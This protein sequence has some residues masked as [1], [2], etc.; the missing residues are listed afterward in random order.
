MKRKL[1][2]PALWLDASDCSPFFKNI[3]RR[4]VF[5]VLLLLGMA[6]VVLAHPSH[7]KMHKDAAL[8]PTLTLETTGPDSA[9][10]GELITVHIRTIS[11]FTD[12]GSLQY[13]V[14]WDETQLQYVSYV[15]TQIGGMGGDPLLGTGNTANGEL[16]YSWVDPAGLDGEDLADSTVLL[17]ITFQV[18]T[19]SG[20]A[21]V[22]ITGTPLSMEVADNLLAIGTLI[23]QNNADT[24]LVPIE[25]TCPPDITVYES[26]SP[27]PLTGGMPVSG[28]YSG[29][30]VSNDSLFPAIAGIGVHIIT[31]SYTDMN[32]CSNTCT[33]NVTVDPPPA[34]ICPDDISVCIGETPFALT[35]GLPPGGTY[36]GPGVSGGIF[37]PVAAGPGD[38]TI[39]YSVTPTDTCTFL[40][41]VY[42]TAAPPAINYTFP[43]SFNVNVTPGNC[44]ATVTIER[45]NIGLLCLI[46]IFDNYTVFD[47]DISNLAPVEGPAN[48]NGVDD[49]NFLNAVQPLDVC[50][51]TTKFVA[52]QFPVGTTIIPYTWCDNDSNCTTV[53]IT[54]IVNEPEPPQALCQPATISLDAN[55]QA[56]LDPS[57]VDA[58]STD[59]CGPVT[60][61]VS[62]D[63]F[64][65]ADLGSKI[66]V[67]TV[68]DFSPLSPPATCTTTVTILDD[69]PP[70]VNCPV[71]IV[72]SADST[73]CNNT[74]GS[75][76]GLGLTAIPSG[77]PLGGP[78]EYTDNCG[79]KTITYILSGPSGTTGSGDYPI[80][81]G[82]VFNGG[83]TTVTYTFRDT[84]GNTSVCSFNVTVED[85]IPPT[86]GLTC[87]NPPPVNANQGGCI[88]VVNWTPPTFTDNCPGFILVTSSHN[89]GS[90]FFFDTTL[91]TYTAVD[92]AGNI[93]T[94]TFNV[95][96]ND[97]QPP[98]ANCKDITVLLDANG[99]VTVNPAQ[100][101]NGSTDN[102]FYE[103]VNLPVTYN[104][105]QAGPNDYTLTI[106]DAGG[107]LDSA[108]CTV[109]VADTSAP[110]IVN[111]AAF[112]PAEIDLDASCFATLDAATYALNFTMTDNTLNSAP[113]CPLSF[114]IDVDGSGFA[115]SYQFNCADRGVNVVTFRA[116]DVFGNSAVCTKNITVNDVTPPVIFNAD[117]IAPPA[118]TV[119][120]DDYTPLDFAA[121]GQ[122]ALGDVADACDDSCDVAISITFSDATAPGPCDNALIITRTWTVTDLAG[123]E[124]EHTQIISV[125]DTEAPVITGVQTLINLEANNQ[126]ETPQC[127]VEHTVEVFAFN[128]ADNCAGDFADFT[129][130]YEIDF[131]PLGSGSNLNGSGAAATAAFPIGASEVTFTVADPCGNASQVTV[132]VMVDD[133]DGPLVNEPFGAFFGNTKSVC[134]S[135]FTI[136]NATGNCGNNFSWYR[137]YRNIN[138]ENFLDCSTYTVT[139]TISDP[140]VQSAINISAPFVYNNP[141]IFSVFPTTF[142]PVGQTTITYTATDVAGNTTTCAFTVEIIDN[143]A[144]VIACPSDQTLSIT[145]GCTD[146]TFVPSYL[147]GVQITD[148]CPN[149]V[150]LTQT[151]APGA[152][153]SG[154]V[155][156]VQA[157][158]TFTVTIGAQDSFPNNLN[159]TSCTF[160]VTLADGQAPVPVLPFLPDIVTLCGL[161]TVEAPMA[162]DCNGVDF[163]TIYGTPSVPVIDI[164]PPLVPGGP[165]R[166]VLNAGNYAI[167]WSYTD[168]QNNTTTQLQS[169]QILVDNNPP[170]AICRPPFSVDLS[171]AGD[172]ALTI[173]EI[174]NGS[175]DPDGCGPV[176]LSLNPAVL[177]CSHLGAPVSVV[178]T[179]E[180]VNGNTAQCSTEVTVFDV[181]APVLSPI[182]ANDTLPACAPLPAPANITASD[183]CD[184]DV[185]IVYAQDTITFIDAYTY[186]VRRTWTATDDSGNA[187]TGTQIIAVEDSGA[188]VFTGAP[189]TIVVVTD[190]NNLDCQDTVAFDITPFVSDCDST[191]LTITNNLTNQGANYSQILGVGVYN[192]VFTAEDGIGNTAAHAIVL[193]VQDGTDPI[194]ACINGVSVSLQA[195]GTVIITPANI[196]S[197][198]SD[199]CTAQPDLELSVQRLDPLGPDT[200]SITF[201]CADADGVTEHPVRLYVQ[202][203]AGNV[204][205]CETYIV[206]QDNSLPTI[207]SCPPGNTLAC[208]AD[209]SPA[210]QGIAIA[211]DNCTVTSITYTD[212]I[213]PG[214]GNFCY[215]VLRS[216]LAV[217]QAGNSAVCVQTFNVLDTVK[218]VLNLTPADVS[219]S[220][221]DSLVTPPLVEATDNCTDSVNV[222]LTVDTINVAQG[223]CGLF[224][225]T[226]RRTWTATD[227]CGNSSIHTQQVTV[228]DT[229][230]PVFAGLP[231]TVT[232][233]TADSLISQGC[234]VPWSFTLHSF[235]SDCQPDSMLTVTNNAPQGDGGFDISGNYA[236]GIYNIVFT[237]TDACGN[238]S[239]DSVVVQVIDNSI[240]T[241]I[242]NDDVVIAL[243][244]NGQATLSPDDI[245]LGS[246]DNCGID[247][248]YLSQATFDCGDLGINSITLTVVDSS[249]NS[250]FCTVDVNVTPGNNTGFTLVTTS[251]PES[252]SGANDGTATATPVGGSGQFS[253]EWSNGD[254]T[255]TITGLAAGT[256]IVIVTDE[257]SGCQQVDT[258]VV[259]EGIKI[260][261]T[262]GS[263]EGCAGQTISIAVTAANFTD[264]T[265]FNF[266][267]HLPLDSVG[268]ILGITA[269]SIHPDLAD[270]L[271]SNL[272]PGNN[273]AIFWSDTAL[274]L[275]LDSVLFRIDIQLGT[276]AVGSTSPVLITGTPVGLQFIQLVNGNPV[277]VDAA[278]VNG[279]VG[280]V[281]GVPDLEIGGDIQTWNNPVPVPGVDVSLT[282]TITASQTTGAPGTYLFGI[283]DS[284]NTIVKCS[285]VTVG[286]AGITGADILLIKRHVLNIQTLVSPYQYVAA[287]VSGE[288]NL[289]ILDYSRIQQLAL[290]LVDHIT[291]SP[292]WKFVPKSYVFPT[293]PLSQPVPDSISHLPA[294]MSFL[295]DDFV[296]VRMGDVNGNIVPTFTGGDDTDD[297]SGG[298]FR[299]RLDER[300]LQQGESIE[301]PFRASGFHHRSGYQMT[302]R[303]DPSVLELEGIAPGVLPDM[304]GA[305]FGDLW[306]QEGML[307]TLWVTPEPM[308]VADG[309]VLFTLKFKVLRGGKALS[310]VLR[311]A[312][313]LT[314]AE[315]YD[316]D[317]NALPLDFGFAQPSGGAVTA[318]F[319]L[320]QNQPNP[321]DDATTI[322]FRLPE[323]GEAALRVFNASGQLVRT[324]VNHYDK[325]YHELRFQRGDFG[326]PG[327]YYYE[328]E[329]AGHSDRKKM[330]LVE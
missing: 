65:C 109:T 309:E 285:K 83:L 95:I 139:E 177:T 183:V 58:G 75:I 20:V 116:S 167:T 94:C 155:N 84:M 321:F 200:T 222:V 43:D 328:L 8:A 185:A 257:V 301:V 311:P 143:Q 55:G 271:T 191:A 70:T 123:N 296:A 227:D 273:L 180:D 47:C 122:I 253:Y 133:V 330:V 106:R 157:G 208:D 161:D 175:T 244:T 229:I 82:Q 266:T 294:T 226:V 93:G 69:T 140:T 85:L 170:L 153:L 28:T 87:P 78:G 201:T 186:T 112:V 64:S 194:A 98:V 44:S 158:Q 104:C 261:L 269:G 42:D 99:T 1:R 272:L 61:S 96:V 31:Y 117:S 325:G 71:D 248:M 242:C 178:L 114:E 295:D 79:V 233:N 204:S 107:N 49:P 13:S 256:Y 81:P 160:T 40:V 168:P 213:A 4:A 278:I 305:N 74:A 108:T 252:V 289:S 10:C 130:T 318:T 132:T 307:T 142:F 303:F 32:G 329:T 11:G 310:E 102:C 163:D 54:V 189:D 36:S 319:A 26:D 25:V 206:V 212:S 33:F 247:T 115:A 37:D 111:C 210:A 165:P 110:V 215:S 144:P 38:H 236:V 164:L 237:A 313:D 223:N 324:V 17:S 29:P 234:S 221:G 68:N 126:N 2:L 51:P 264:V 9:A 136:L 263:G 300:S 316:A 59:N 41:S 312:S 238:E 205:T 7:V 228:T 159:A 250:N 19:S 39:T 197:N 46:P 323:A 138:E 5:P 249:G 187:T 173:P 239:V 80:P 193:V 306:A 121:L 240:P 14:N 23:A 327:V 113:P 202:D 77:S 302:L 101:D 176:D 15:A 220:C 179:A 6:Q 103:Y 135:T 172:Y 150:V 119:E 279:Q 21:S 131:A 207:T 151:P 275:P 162:L 125:V 60:L 192:L 146:S 128:V 134:D 12:I 184:T 181:T 27:F 230:A 251:T 66:V 45:P 277:T 30:G 282:G 203:E 199:N 326:A 274:T 317:G 198:S 92:V 105:T 287:D 298:V 196:N 224:S 169:V 89:P 174:D 283:P 127:A 254:S 245:D 286:N 124:T 73:S 231:D 88:A 50:D 18:L 145:S 246:N 267:L 182:P 217:D 154:V 149:N 147:N 90:F 214:T 52:I 148:N 57:A 284:A 241:A 48:V 216:W 288:G 97:A 259:D 291:G 314:R 141:P 255:A 268:A 281:C 118:V 218:P 22:D 297:R 56:V 129:I 24:E 315:G 190:L 308:T 35:G 3:A 100:V 262:V 91:V 290:A 322:A 235:L 292:D 188:P 209:F 225:Y 195:S 86:A 120:C 299:F 16:T 62:P 219:I 34:V 243:G 276:A 76:P 265:N 232:L 280:I 156:P 67:L 258:V 53:N 137:P 72:V 211:D 260:T 166:Y 63:T 304:N 270:G 320:Y 171:A 293:P 152:L